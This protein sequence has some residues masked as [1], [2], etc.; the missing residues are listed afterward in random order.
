MVCYRN[1]RGHNSRDRQEPYVL[2]R[3]QFGCVS[4]TRQGR[5]LREQPDEVGNHA[6]ARA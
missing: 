1:T 2:L 4:G 3:L 6:P 5:E